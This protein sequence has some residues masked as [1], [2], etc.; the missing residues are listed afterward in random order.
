MYE[1]LY[2]QMSKKL[3]EKLYF[4]ILTVIALVI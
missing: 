2:L 3:S 4:R 1:K